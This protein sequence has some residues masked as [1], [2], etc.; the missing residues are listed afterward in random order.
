MSPVVVLKRREQGAEPAQRVRYSEP[1]ETASWLSQD[2]DTFEL[3]VPPGEFSTPSLP[4]TI[5]S[6]LLS[7]VD[8]V[9]GA[10][11]SPELPAS[12]EPHRRRRSA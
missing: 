3:T 8:L 5:E 2:S 4:D 7:L 9:P 12:A 11:P 10:E 1:P 6:A